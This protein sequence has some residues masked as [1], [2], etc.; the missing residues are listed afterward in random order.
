M[1][2]VDLLTD[3]SVGLA[4]IDSSWRLHACFSPRHHANDKDMTPEQSSSGIRLLLAEDNPADAELE[5]R[6][7]RRAGIRFT[8]RVVD[9]REEFVEAIRQSNPDII[10]SDFSMPRFDGMSALRVAHDLAPD[11]P[12][13]FVSGTLGEAH[14][15]SALKEGATDYVLKHNLARL[16]SAVERALAEAKERRD[17]RRA[18]AGLGR[19]QSMAKLAHVITGAG[20][21]FETWSENLPHGPSSTARHAGSPSTTASSSSLGSAWWTTWRGRL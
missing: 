4:Y 10:M 13:I 6:E 18:Q 20:G 9:T 7:L 2:G 15:I 11:T 19:A 8:V 1:R 3:R 12:F 5:L 21:S 14:A 17:R 16:P